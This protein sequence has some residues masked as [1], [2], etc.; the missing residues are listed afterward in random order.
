MYIIYIMKYKFILEN[1]KSG[2][3]TQY[4]TLKEISEIIKIPYHQARSI[5]LSDK[6]QFIHKN[7][8]EYCKKYK[9]YD[10][11][12]VISVKIC[13]NPDVINVVN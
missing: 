5:Y 11:P 6:K 4:R 3:K 10:N 8:K 1:C 13:D 7:I 12:D 9:I 2:K